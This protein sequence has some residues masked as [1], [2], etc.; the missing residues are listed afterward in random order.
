M[1]TEKPR[2]TITTSKPI[3]ETISR[4]AKLQRR[5]KSAV[6]NEL[7]E[8]VHDPLR[9][10][11]VLLEAANEAPKQVRD[12]L[13]ATIEQLEYEL[14]GDLGKGQAQ[15]DLLINQMQKQSSKAR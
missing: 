6:V 11:L 3:Y 13:R 9:R 12:G 8:A 2:F 1:P 7:L 14:T 15:L 4:L 10:T 5:S